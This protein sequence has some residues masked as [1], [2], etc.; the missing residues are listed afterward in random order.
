MNI[1]LDELD[2]EILE[3]TADNDEAAAPL[4]FLNGVREKNVARFTPNA[5]PSSPP[6]GVAR[7]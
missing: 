5:C 2:V 4:A 7:R 6:C 1:S 3:S